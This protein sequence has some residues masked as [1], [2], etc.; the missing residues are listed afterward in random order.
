M[1]KKYGLSWGGDWKT[2]IDKP[3]FEYEKY[4]TTN[5]L[6]KKYCTPEN[7]MKTWCNVEEKGEVSYLKVQRNYSCDGEIKSVEVINDNG[8]NYVKVRDLANLL[9]LDIK[10]D[11]K[12]KITELIKMLNYKNFNIEKENISID[13]MHKSGTTY[14]NVRKLADLLGYNTSYNENT[15]SI[16]FTKKDESIVDKVKN[17]IK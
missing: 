12:T 13:T 17:F 3:H 1:L 8:S 2:T 15:K 16:F 9:G 11:D 7:F 4:G 10:Y 5:S 14:A 6:V